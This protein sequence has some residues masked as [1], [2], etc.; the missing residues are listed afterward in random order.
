VYC[1]SGPRGSVL[2][3]GT[4]GFHF[5]I[6]E[7]GTWLEIGHL[8]ARLELAGRMED[9]EEAQAERDDVLPQFVRAG[10]A[11]QE[12]EQFLVDVKRTGEDSKNRIVGHIVLSLSFSVP[13]TTVSLKT[14]QSSR[15]T[16][17]KLTP[18]TSSER[19]LSLGPR[20]CQD[21]YHLDA[22]RPR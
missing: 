20:P 12:L 14:L 13:G 22:P 21:P 11:I 4:N 1:G 7:I 8:E 17:T 10:R 16:P 19:P 15:S 6:Q 3:F 18:P 2:S 5:R 9:P